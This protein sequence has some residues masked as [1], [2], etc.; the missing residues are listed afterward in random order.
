MAVGLASL[1]PQAWAAPF[2]VDQGGSCCQ[3]ESVIADIGDA[4]PELQAGAHVWVTDGSDEEDCT[5]GGGTDKHLCCYDGTTWV[6]C[7]AAGTGGG[8]DKT[9]VGEVPGDLDFDGADV[10][11]T[12]ANTPASADEIDIFFSGFRPSRVASGPDVTQ[13]T[14]SGASVT[15]GLAPRSDDVLTVT[16]QSQ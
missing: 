16:Y 9:V 1:A 13:F 6:I 3:Q 7:T 15:L 12:L 5:S 10:T 14:V 11:F 8:A 2:C 4:C